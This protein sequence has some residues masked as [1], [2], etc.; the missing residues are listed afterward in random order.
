M[1]RGELPKSGELPK[2]LRVVR[3]KTTA[4]ES[5]R[6]K[7]GQATTSDVVFELL[8]ERLGR[9]IVEVMVVVAV[10]RALRIVA[11]NEVARGT[12]SSLVAA[13]SDIFRVPVVVGARGIILAHNHPSGDPTPSPEDIAMTKKTVLAG[14]ALGI[15]VFDHLVVT[16]SGYRSAMD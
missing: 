12:T 5:R 3:E 9:E 14:E 8:K 1:E 4:Y 11:L 16:S 10:D 2:W 15:D 7:L 13:T 6:L